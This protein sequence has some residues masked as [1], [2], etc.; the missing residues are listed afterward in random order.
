MWRR[1]L[2]LEVGVVDVDMAG[3]GSVLDDPSGFDLIPATWF[4]GYTDPEYFLRLLLHSEASSNYGRFSYAPYDELV[5]CTCRA[6]EE[7]TRLELFHEADRMA[8]AEVV[9][10]IP[11]TYHRNISLSR[12]H[13]KGW[14][15]FG[16][17]W[18]NFAD[19]VVDSP[20]T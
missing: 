12:P 10:V 3:W 20:Q 4:P 5:E 11:L 9:G 19:L 14:W 13:V 1:H 7:R 2:D 18:A 17:S 8:V 15:E 6:T 16:K